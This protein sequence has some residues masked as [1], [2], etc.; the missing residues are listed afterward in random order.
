M[1]ATPPSLTLGSLLQMVARPGWCRRMLGTPRRRLGNLVGHVKGADDLQSMA[2]WADMQFDLALSWA[3]V[4]WIAARWNGPLIIKGVMDPLDAQ[5]AAR[6][7]AQA[8]VVSNHG[9]RQLDGSP[10][11]IRMLPRIV[12]AV[13]DRLEV[14]LDGG[15]RSG[16]D[17]FRAIALGA[18]GT[19]IG[20]PFLYGLGALGEAGVTMALEIIR[21]ELDVTMALCGERRI[22]GIGL[23]NLVDL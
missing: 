22:T 5:A 20:R 1:A 4:D 9:G 16:Q 12:E 21:K 15:I 23:H 19:Y 8:I 7:G 6:T 17:V 2:K 13:G 3:D 18:K 10:S 11:T 14:H